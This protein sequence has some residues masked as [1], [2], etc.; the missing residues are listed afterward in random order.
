MTLMSW[1]RKQS[2]KQML[3][4]ALTNFSLAGRILTSVIFKFTQNPSIIASTRREIFSNALTFSRL[5]AKRTT[6]RRQTMAKVNQ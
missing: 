1:T 6:A 4:Y 2:L 3:A 5:S